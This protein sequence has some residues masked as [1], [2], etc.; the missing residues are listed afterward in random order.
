MMRLV[1]MYE[2]AIALVENNPEIPINGKFSNADQGLYVVDGTCRIAWRVD[3]DC[4]CSIA[5]RRLDVL[6]TRDITIEA[7]IHEDRCG[8]GN[9]DLSREGSP[10][11]FWD[12]DLVTRIQQHHGG[13]K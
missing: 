8:A 9:Q 4:P 13:V 1:T 7:C 12:N 2:I 5:D 11:G 3:D 10:I 6:D